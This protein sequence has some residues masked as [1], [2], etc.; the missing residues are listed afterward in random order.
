MILQ[1]KSKSRRGIVILIV[2]SLLVLFIVLAVTFAIVAGQYRRAAEAQAKQELLGGE[3]K[4]HL[5]MALYQLIR[6][7]NDKAASSLWGH[8]L[9]RDIYGADFEA[10][11]VVDAKVP[12]DATGTKINSQVLVLTLS[13]DLKHQEEGYYGGRVFTMLDGD[14]AGHSVRILYS[15][16]DNSTPK[17]QQL[18]VEMP[19]VDSPALFGNLT[20]TT[21]TPNASTV[22][23][24]HRFLINGGAFNG[25]GYGY[26]AAT[27]NLSQDALKPNFPYSLTSSPKTLP[28]GGA[29][30]PYDVADFRD[31][32]LAMVPPNV[33]DSQ[34]IIPSFHRPE[35]I[36]YWAN[37]GAQ[38]G[39]TTSADL[40]R[41]I[42]L[43][44]L[45]LKDQHPNFTGSNPAAGFNAPV[46]PANNP[47]L[48][49]LLNALVNGPWDVD[50]DNDGIP[51]SVWLDLQLP[52]VTSSNGLKYK[53]LVAILCRD[54][55]GSLNVNAAGHLLQHDSQFQQKTSSQA[56][57]G[58]VTQASLPRG[59]GQ[60][61]PEINLSRV[62]DRATAQKYYAKLMTNRYRSFSDP[63]D[64]HPGLRSTTNNNVVTDDKLILLKEMGLPYKYGQLANDTDYGSYSN[65]SAYGTYPDFVGRG[66]LALDYHG[67]PLTSFTGDDATFTIDTTSYTVN[68][69]RDSPYQMNLVQPN[70]Q[71]S[72]YTIYE[73]E[74]HLRRG[75]VDS[76]V[77]PTRLSALALSGA[78]ITT[79]SFDVPTGNLPGP[80]DL[81]GSATTANSHAAQLM[82]K[83][84]ADPPNNITNP[85]V[86]EA[87]LRLM[88]PFEFLH[89]KK[90]D[91]N[92]AWGNGKDDSTL[93]DYVVDDLKELLTTET[94]FDDANLSTNGVYQNDYSD[95]ALVAADGRQIYA[96][97]LYCLMMLLMDS[98]YVPPYAESTLTQAEKQELL[99]RR[100]AQW[101]VNVV[102][103]RDSDAIMTRF[104]YDVNPFNGW[105]T[106]GSD[107]RVVWGCEYPELMITEAT[108]LH[109][110]RV[111]DLATD[112]GSNDKRIKNG[113]APPAVGDDDLDQFRIPLGSLFVELYCPRSIFK[114]KDTSTPPNDIPVNAVVPREL[115]AISGS[116]AYLD[117][118]RRSPRTKVQVGPYTKYTGYP[119]WRLAISESH[120][121]APNLAKSPLSRQQ[122]NPDSTTYQSDNMGKIEGLAIERYV[123]FAYCD[124]DSLPQPPALPAF[125]P[126]QVFWNQNSS[127]SVYLAPGGYAVVGPRPVTPVGSRSDRTADSPQTIE[128]NVNASTVTVNS[129]V[130]A[131]TPV[132]AL[133]IIASAKAADPTWPATDPRG[134]NVSEPLPRSGNYYAKPTFK[135]PYSTYTTEND[136]YGDPIIGDTTFPDRP[137]DSQA[138]HPLKDDNLLAT[139]TTLNYK[140]LFLQRLADPLQPYDPV[141]NPYITVDW[142]P[143]DLTVFN[144]E[145]RAPNAFPGPPFPPFD[146]DDPT[147]DEQDVSA[148]T[149]LK[150][151]TRY[152]GDVNDK[153][154][155]WR[156][157]TTAPIKSVPNP[158]APQELYFKHDLTSASL[159]VPAN[160]L[161][162]LNTC[163]GVPQIPPAVPP[164]YQ[165]CPP[166]PFPWLTWNNRPF[167]SPLELLLVPSSSPGK[168]FSDYGLRNSVPNPY[169]P[170]DVSTYQAPF[171]HLLNFFNSDLS[172][173]KGANLYRIL[174]LLEVPSPFVGT[175]KWYNPSFFQPFN[176]TT[177]DPYFRTYRPPFN[178]LSRFR[179]PGKVNINTIFDDEVWK[180]MVL[181]FPNGD[182]AGTPPTSWW[183]IWAKVKQSR[184]GYAPAAVNTTDL[185]KPLN[186]SASLNS[187]Y[188]TRFAGVFQPAST[189]DLGA[190]ANLRMEGVQATL[191]R[192]ETTNPASP[193]PLFAV[194][195]S[196]YPE[197]SK[198]HRNQ[199]RNPFFYYQGLERLWNLTTTRSN[200][201]AVWMTLGYFEVDAPGQPGLGQE[202]GSDTGEVKRHRSFYIIDRSIPVAFEPGENHNVD[203]CILLRRYI[204]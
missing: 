72:P 44:P 125:N 2:L 182:Y 70:G 8:G 140:T 126:D 78:S 1:S 69:R 60:G 41:K 34:Q 26:D 87:Q 188:P 35:L 99:A 138:N 155:L 18:V 123:W 64:F 55:D 48:L 169:Q 86:V 158:T 191:L 157:I 54:L 66:T 10:G 201:F 179:D 80:N 133:G 100:V 21:G 97:H 156:Q 90:M 53:P 186:F 164:E 62:F 24:K 197:V 168:L 199:D 67:N 122:T 17:L 184:Q 117:L 119:V 36:N 14:A 137:F 134:A 148:K 45:P 111:R 7:P 173:I 110:R 121:V 81:R 79:H 56:L 85:T 15:L 167:V 57:A 63:L 187:D 31:M 128:I 174:D 147:Q 176:D 129:T 153:Q 162:F 83:R 28:A 65:P 50:N 58:A 25:T 139:A 101:A 3:E 42:T 166:K 76:S 200:V 145:D 96:R 106:T 195:A 165:G 154:N 75:D 16:K 20:N 130:G 88:L 132:S 180:A 171:S 32:F 92:R 192:S 152:R 59:R 29:N 177:Y 22:L 127:Q 84:L 170:T 12:I 142:C 163:Y 4:R 27:K 190:L 102:D 38:G 181:G 194:D 104:V 136:A 37:N 73:L 108:A 91:I 49:V 61:P 105:D 13:A 47:A 160:T 120:H 89:G 103:F 204:E 9:L 159:G 30:E 74:A 114:M 203:R 115:Y 193:L 175:E 189:A 143:I 185:T 98:T 112:D 141:N 109:D 135:L 82:A 94:V 196:S 150:F 144:G 95:P 116:Q 5:D 172:G 46:D 33:S 178:S 43:R 146:P 68:E 93:A 77:L 113:S 202:I 131:G 183:D 107:G 149:K 51:D 39:G 11:S 198:D 118:G 161:G 52:V 151:M 19:T 40:L 6:D 23:S 124:P 71:D